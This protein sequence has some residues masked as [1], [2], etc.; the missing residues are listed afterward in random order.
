MHADGNKRLLLA[1]DQKR[2]GEP[3][4]RLTNASTVFLPVM[5]ASGLFSM[6][7]TVLPFTPS[8]PA[9]LFAVG[10]LFIATLML[11]NLLDPV[12]KWFC[13]RAKDV[14]EYCASTF[15]PGLYLAALFRYRG[16][17]AAKDTEA[18]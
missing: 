16:T 12:S 15:T 7:D 11:I 14:W 10:F 18:G 5:L 8:F 2:S 4:R 6:A 9:F 17:P 3:N 13:D 1:E